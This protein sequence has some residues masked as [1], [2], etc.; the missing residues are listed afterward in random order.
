M[1]TLRAIAPDALTEEQAAEELAALAAEIAHHDALYH[2]SDRP[3]ISDAAYDA[4]K[5]R[6]DAIEARFPALVRPDSPNRRV[7]AAPAR[8]FAK[9]RH[10]RPMLSLDNAFGADE[11]GEFVFDALEFLK[12]DDYSRWN[13]E[14]PVIFGSRIGPIGHVWFGPKYIFSTYS[15]DAS[16]KNI[17]VVPESSGTIHHLGGFAGIGLGYKVVFVFL[18]LT[19]AKMFAEPNFPHPPPISKMT[20]MIFCYGSAGALAAIIAIG[21]NLG[22]AIAL[23]ARI[24]VDRWPSRFGKVRDWDRHV[25]E[26]KAAR[27][28]LDTMLDRLRTAYAPTDIIADPDAVTPGA[29]STSFD[30]RTFSFG[31]EYW[32]PPSMAS[33]GVR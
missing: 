2:Q 15:L 20:K 4:L 26:I 21:G 7:G 22:V 17:G 24:A 32:N 6:N 25:A 19:V 23:A 1:S 8:G 16:L 10:R 12:V 11:F 33:D 31:R 14:L 5:R 18:E 30:S 29:S 27:A 13:V 3:E 9:A 28:R